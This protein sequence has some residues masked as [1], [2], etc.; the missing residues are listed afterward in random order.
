[1]RLE[2]VGQ[3]GGNADALAL[4]GDTIYLKAG[5]R[6]ETIDVSNPY[7]PTIIGRS[8]PLSEEIA[9]IAVLDNVALVGGKAGTLFVLD[10][11][12]DSDSRLIASLNINERAISHIV[13][14][15]KFAF[16]GVNGPDLFVIDHSDPAHPTLATTVPFE[17]SASGMVISADLLLMGYDT[18][19]IYNIHDPAHPDKVGSFKV[20]GQ[21]GGLAISGEAVYAGA[22][23]FD[24]SD[25]SHPNAVSTGGDPRDAV[26]ASGDTIIGYT[27]RW[28][29]HTSGYPKIILFDAR[30]PQNIIRRNRLPDL[31]AGE[32]LSGPKLAVRGHLLFL[33]TANGLEIFDLS[34][35][36]QREVVFFDIDD[37]YY[38]EWPR[39]GFVRTNFAETYVACCGAMYTGEMEIVGGYLYTYTTDSVSVWNLDDP[40]NPSL[41]RTLDRRWDL[42]GCRDTAGGCIRPGNFW[43]GSYE[44]MDTRDPANPVIHT[45][46]ANLGRGEVKIVSESIMVFEA[47]IPGPPDDQG[48]PGDTTIELRTYDITNPLSPVHLGSFPLEPKHYYYQMNGDR[49][50]AFSP[51]YGGE[52]TVVDISDP[53]NPVLAADQSWETSGGSVAHVGDTVLSLDGGILEVFATTDIDTPLSQIRVPGGD[54]M[55]Y[56]DGYLWARTGGDHPAMTVIDVSN[57]RQPRILARVEIDS[58]NTAAAGD[59][60]YI[61]DWFSNLYI[62]H[63]VPPG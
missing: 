2:Q 19:S 54:Q 44:F 20:S 3:F 53:R 8:E 1:M 36:P 63:L 47:Y 40:A 45:V 37:A 16:V 15:D 9:S 11:P 39:I 29:T 17:Q 49:V 26:T 62:F 18:I 41:I 38:E 28:D 35:T 4:V 51:S 32:V 27:T 22:D 5:P 46:N 56:S 13:M 24:I 55:W 31:P 50:Q 10:A 12:P 43:N 6:L 59:Y 60:I 14:R 48:N 25:P 58:Y 33:G 52:S 21:K 30:D 23:V 42:S 57:P 34:A 7:N 61:S